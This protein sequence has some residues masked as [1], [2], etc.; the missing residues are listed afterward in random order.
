MLEISNKTNLLEQKSYKYSL[1]DV[2]EPNLHRDVYS[3]GTIPKVAFNHRRVPMSMP[4]EIWITDT[5]LRDG[6]QSVEPYS[7]DQIVKQTGIKVGMKMANAMIKKIPG[8][9]L[10]KINQKV[11]FRLL[12]KFGTTGVINLGKMIPFVG[13]IIGGGFDFAE[14]KIIA[15]RA[16][17][18]FI[19]NDFSVSEKDKK[20]TIDVDDFEIVEEHVD[21]E[22]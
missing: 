5:S 7:V 18:M 8:S 6:Q 16:Y 9:A 2:A 15:D 11:G 20:N 1:Q 10:T 13:G 22:S 21:L 19:L 4:E 14:T 3:Y 12:T 17:K